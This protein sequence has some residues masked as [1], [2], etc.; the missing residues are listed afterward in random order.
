[1]K[2][3]VGFHSASASSSNSAKQLNIITSN[4]DLTAPK[5][6]HQPDPD[7]FNMKAI[8]LHEL[9]KSPD[10]LT[11]SELPDLKPAKD[12]YLIK[13][14][15]AATNFFDVLQVQG[16]HQQKP[17]LPWIAGNELAGEIVAQ[18][19][20]PQSKPKFKVGDNVFGAALG[21]FATQ[22]HVEEEALRPMPEG[23]SYA[24]ASGL[25][26]TAPTAYAALILRARAQKG[27]NHCDSK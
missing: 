10:G 19:T 16:K 23:W 25:F 18:P 2:D 27:T 20:S 17:D 22:I 9:V 7:L 1:M 24:Q 12:K 5:P 11:I 4:K 15:A 3:G 14:H 6:C 26:Y 21:T 13:I 8:Q